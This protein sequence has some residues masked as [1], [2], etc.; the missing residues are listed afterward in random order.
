MATISAMGGEGTLHPASVGGQSRTAAA[1]QNDIVELR[2]ELH[3]LRAA[4]DA[5]KI[6]FQAIRDMN[7]HATAYVE[8]LKQKI[9]RR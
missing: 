9:E 5:L 2:R 6:E 4:F 7:R 8:F 3:E 1:V